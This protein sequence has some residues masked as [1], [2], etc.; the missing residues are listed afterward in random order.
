M[1]R[2]HIG[3]IHYSHACLQQTT[4]FEAKWQNKF[5]SVGKNILKTFNTFHRDTKQKMKD[6]FQNS[7]KCPRGKKPIVLKQHSLEHAVAQPYSLS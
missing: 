5:F 6:T 3:Q 7:G 2:M 1:F 4:I